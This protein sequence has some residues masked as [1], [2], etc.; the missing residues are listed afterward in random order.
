MVS[1]LDFES[2]DPSSNLGRTSIKPPF[3]LCFMLI[4]KE[5]F[6]SNIAWYS[7]TVWLCLNALERSLL[8]STL[9]MLFSFTS[10]KNGRI[11]TTCTWRRAPCGQFIGCPQTFVDDQWTDRCTCASALLISSDKSTF[12][13]TTSGTRTSMY[14]ASLGFAELRDKQSSTS[15]RFA[16]HLHDDF[17]RNCF[18]SLFTVVIYK[19]VPI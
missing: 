16:I 6:S 19:P 3:Y 9:M 18:S 14:T 5:K 1:T 2:S 10:L 7:Y 17:L 8:K 4:L 15:N 12:S 11:I 13:A